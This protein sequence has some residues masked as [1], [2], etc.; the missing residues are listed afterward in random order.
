MFTLTIR[1]IFLLF[2]AHFLKK[3]ASFQAT[4]II[5]MHEHY[6]NPLPNAR[7]YVCRAQTKQL[8]AL[9]YSGRFAEAGES[10]LLCAVTP[11]TK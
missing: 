7:M 1:H 10:I 4:L 6:R 8:Y 2:T 11:V 9:Q 3:L 5:H